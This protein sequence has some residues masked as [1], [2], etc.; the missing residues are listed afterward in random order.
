MVE[1]EDSAAPV[2]QYT[3]PAVLS[4]SYSIGQ[5]MIPEQL[6][7][8]ESAG[9]SGV[10]DSGIARQLNADGSLGPVSTLIGTQLSWGL[11]GQALFPARSG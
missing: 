10:Y 11:L 2:Q 1:D 4:R 5:P 3:G 9:V 6:K 7:W 8:Q